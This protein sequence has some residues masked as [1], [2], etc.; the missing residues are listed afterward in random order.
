MAVKSRRKKSTQKA[1][2]PVELEMMSV[3]WR[4]GGCTVAQIRS[5][6]LPERDLAYTSVSTIVR[7]LEQKGY[8]AS[9]KDGRGHLYE[10]LIPKQDY[11]ESS[12]KQLVQSVF[13]D[14]PS[15]LV[16]RLLDSNALTAGDLA[17]IKDLVKKRT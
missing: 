3:I 6:L 8:L 15:L 16:Q 5:A 11:Q 9:K 7:I 4:I 2:T 17:Q 10:A 12:L 1:L 13:D 14:E